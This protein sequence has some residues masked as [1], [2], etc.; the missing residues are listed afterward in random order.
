[1]KKTIRVVVILSLVWIAAVVSVVGAL[2]VKALDTV[3]FC[4]ENDVAKNGDFIYVTDNG[5]NAGIV[6]RFDYDGNVTGFFTTGKLR[7]LDGF[8][9]K[10]VTL[11]NDEPQIVFERVRD[12]NGRIITEYSVLALNEDMDPSFITPPFRFGLE[13]LLTGFYATEDTLYL[14]AVP[15]NRNLA[16]VY[17][18]AA[19]EM[20]QIKTTQL[21]GEDVSKWKQEKVEVKENSETGCPSDRY[22]A[23]A[24]Y[25]EDGLQ[26][27]YDN[28]VSDYFAVDTEAEDIYNA[29]RMSMVQSLEMSGLVMPVFSLLIFVGI[30]LIVLAAYLQRG[31]RRI[32]YAAAASELAV[33]VFLAAVFSYLIFANHGA[34]ESEF[35]RFASADLLNVFD[36]YGLTDLSSDGLYDEE[37]YGVVCQRLRRMGADGVA[38][39][40]SLD[41]LSTLIM[42]EEGN[43][44][45]SGDGRNLAHVSALYG[46]DV[47]RLVRN[48]IQTATARTMKCIYNGNNTLF[49]SLPLVNAGYNGYAGL[50]VA[51][52]EELS[53]YL[54]NDYGRVFV[55]FLV[56]FVL[57]SI[58]V[59]I[60]M[61]AQNRDISALQQAL[62]QLADGESNINKPVV[63]G[64]DM[65]FI[66]NSVFEIQ[67]NILHTNRIKFLTY[68]AY[69][70]FAPKGVERI[71]K[72]QSITEVGYGDSVTLQGTIAHISSRS[73]FLQDSRQMDEF[74]NRMTLLEECQ[75]EHDGIFISHDNSLS[76]LKL[77][78]LE[79]NCNTISFGIDFLF[80]LREESGLVYSKL[81]MILHYTPFVYGIVGSNDQASI[82]MFTPHEDMLQRY[83]EWFRSMHMGLI[84]TET[85]LQHEKVD[86]EYRYIGFIVPDPANPQEQLKLYEVLDA[87][88]IRVR[89]ERLNSLGR[90][91][92]ALDLFYQQD[93]YFARNMFTEIVKTSSDDELA[94]WYLFECEKYLNEAAPENF[95]GALNMESSR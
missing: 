81:T 5:K 32:V 72:R 91:Q 36:G 25:N 94:K 95:V 18:V 57:A 43:V 62:E 93:F 75:K 74:N 31:R 59:M 86:Y 21:S 41:M 4:A 53:S 22:I 46:N 63:V 51:Q 85:V 26:V 60:F 16:Y 64:K 69:F 14:T 79:N 77:L 2:W 39:S 44:I 84:I 15:N 54:L 1:M 89:K 80:K 24:E 70:R 82:Y 83:A 92:E 8:H 35:I 40:S 19:S 27:R 30:A 10:K 68:E 34:Q 65:N 47:E 49:L 52:E 58:A 71:L 61:L 28:S 50:I 33:F 37:D 9:A 20:K 55:A 12:D 45:L 17:E 56:A 78:F 13:L 73:Q 48:S 88:S 38:G 42:S 23:E 67:K 66:W 6:W 11:V 76:V 90:F 3:G 7:Y 29:K 87:E